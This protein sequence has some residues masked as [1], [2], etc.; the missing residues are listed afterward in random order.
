MSRVVRNALAKLH[1][2]LGH[3]SNE[4]MARMLSLEGASKEVLEACKALRCDICSRLAPPQSEPK[5]SA[6]QPRAFNKQTLH[7][8]FF[9]WDAN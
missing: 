3:V 9:I 4:K 7:D 8:T 1:C 2:T 6:Q 5:L